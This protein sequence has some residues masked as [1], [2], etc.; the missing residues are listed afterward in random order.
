[1]GVVFCTRNSGRR[2]MQMFFWTSL[3]LILLMSFT[4]NCDLEKLFV[5][6]FHFRLI[7]CDIHPTDLN[8]LCKNLI[9]CRNQLDLEWV[10]CQFP[11]SLNISQSH[12]TNFFLIVFSYSFSHGRLMDNSIETLVRLIPNMTSLNLLK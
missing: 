4:T 5:F 3:N 7:Q 10:H 8:K 2:L 12:I 6:I 11:W 1:M 9:K